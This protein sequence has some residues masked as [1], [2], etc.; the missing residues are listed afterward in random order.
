MRRIAT[1]AAFLI[2]ACAAC[3]QGADSLSFD[4]ASVKPSPPVKAGQRVYYGPA[5]GGPGTAD[6]G[7]ITWTYA[8]FIDLLMA[9]YDVKS[10]QISGPAWI[11]SERYDVLVKLPADATKEQVRV[12]WGNLL[13]DRFGLKVHHEAREFRVEELVVAKGG[14]KLRESV[15]DPTP[16]LNGE[17]PKFRDGAL[18]GPGFVLTISPGASRAGV[19]AFSR[20][21]P[22]SK[23]TGTLTNMV[24]RPVLDK[25]GLTGNYDFTLEFSL[26]MGRLA[27]PA[28]VDAADDAT[29]PE[30]DVGAALQDQLGLRLIAAMATLDVV[31][32]DAAGKIPTSN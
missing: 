3:A 10:Y 2:F 20:A 24:N 17:P 29:E 1:E 26:D 30:L 11:N 13:A 32:V 9:V 12:M 7:Q 4:V 28:P 25:T 15:E 31:V 6:P 16:S 19:H 5:R 21:Q 27:A 23:L 14:P 8:R 22:L 18:E